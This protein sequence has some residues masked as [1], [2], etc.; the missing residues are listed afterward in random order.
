MIGPILTASFSPLLAW[1]QPVYILS[2]FAGI[3][4][5]SLM[6]IQP[7][8]VAGQVPGVSGYR[9]RSL[10]KLVGI[11]LLSSIF[12]HVAGLWVTSPPDVVDVL[13][14]RSPAPFSVWGV[15]AMWAILAAGL[16]AIFRKRLRLRWHTW[17]VA[18]TTL[19]GITV[20]GTV[21]HALLIEGT[22]E[23]ISKVVICTT[24]LIVTGKVFFDL[25]VWQMRRKS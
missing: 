11:A 8:L 23:T 20:S 7:L 5:L 24:V 22:M 10:H 21:V 9:G 1:R 14:F 19:A 3:L 6:L 13:L 2:G 17:R 25:K 18:H 12:V 15:L 4:G 16:L